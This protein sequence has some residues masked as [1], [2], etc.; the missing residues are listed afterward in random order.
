MPVEIGKQ[1]IGNLWPGARDFNTALGTLTRNQLASH[2]DAA[3]NGSEYIKIL[4][5]AL[6][7]RDTVAYMTIV[8][9]VELD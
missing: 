9:G 2:I 4:E 7:Y 5:D 1:L 6:Y 3:V 8:R